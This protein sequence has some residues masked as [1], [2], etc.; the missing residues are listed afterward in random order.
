MQGQET[1]W[2][3]DCAISGNTIV[4][5]APLAAAPR[6]NSGAAYVFE[7]KGDVW[8][9][10]AKLVPHDGDGG[11][12]FGILSMSVRNRVIVGQIRMRITGI[13]AVPVRRISLAKLR[14][15][16]PKRQS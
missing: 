15:P 8:A 16:T 2:G 12:A 14:A 9:Q 4:A 10:M 1:G 11:D 6:R 7:R 13:G 3:W 5:G